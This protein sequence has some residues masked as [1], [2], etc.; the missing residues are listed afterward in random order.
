MEEIATAIQVK[1]NSILG[2]F[3]EKEYIE[4]KVERNPDNSGFTYE[5]KLNKDKFGGL[6]KLRK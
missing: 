6:S 1:K 5:Y 2:N 3:V 4:E